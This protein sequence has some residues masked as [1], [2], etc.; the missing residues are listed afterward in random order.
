LTLKQVDFIQLPTV[1]FDFLA[2]LGWK[3]ISWILTIR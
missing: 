1:D 3:W 2:K